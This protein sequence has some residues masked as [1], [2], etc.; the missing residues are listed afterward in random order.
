VRKFAQAGLL[1]GAALTFTL[2][3]GSLGPALAAPQAQRVVVKTAK[4]KQLGKTVLVTRQG[5]TLYFLTA[6][7]RG[8]FICTDATCL[9]LWRPLTVPRGTKPAGVRSLGTV[10]R[11]DGR[12]QVTFRNHPLYRFKNDRKP[13]DAN[14]NGFKDV[15]TWLAA[16]TGGKKTTAPPPS[17]GYGG[18]YGGSG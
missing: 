3:A 13:G 1:A 10:K 15:G 2:S 11:P 6:E 16:S 7:V 4:N 9:S 18:G 8:K 14:G 17:G 12:T 5:R